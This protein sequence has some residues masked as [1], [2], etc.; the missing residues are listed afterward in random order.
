MSVGL[1]LFRCIEFESMNI[2]SFDSGCQN[3]DISG[4][5]KHVAT[6][7]GGVFRKNQRLK[8]TSLGRECWTECNWVAEGT[9]VRPD[10]N[11]TWFCWLQ[12][13]CSSILLFMQW[14]ITL[15]AKKK[16]ERKLHT[17]KAGVSLITKPVYALSFEH[18]CTLHGQVMFIRGCGGTLC[19]AALL[20][21]LAAA[22]G[23]WTLLST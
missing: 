17:L 6:G 18:R 7:G 8:L 4:H 15:W 9:T 5:N 19:T 10:N 14:I 2:V 11:Q 3:T 1:G 23:Q 21:R 13:Y 20:C 12:L 22:F 16:E